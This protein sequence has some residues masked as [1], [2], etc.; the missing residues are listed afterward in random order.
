RT[1]SRQIVVARRVADRVALDR[2]ADLVVQRRHALL[3]AARRD[4]PEAVV[5]APV[6]NVELGA[7]DPRRLE[8]IDKLA[9][10]QPI[11]VKPEERR[12][13]VLDELPLI[14]LTG[15]EQVLR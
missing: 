12:V 15:A 14:D 1:A 2:T 13:A 6:Q 3:A 10:L 4:A 11:E 7:L 5:R 9:V 8:A